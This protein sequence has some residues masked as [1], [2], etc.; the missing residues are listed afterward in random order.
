MTA[1]LEQAYEDCRRVVRASGSSF[2]AGMQLLPLDRRPAIFA[3]YALA[4][5]ID[6]IADGDL[7]TEAKLARFDRLRSELR[8]AEEP[9]NTLVLAVRDAAERFP[10]PL[11]AFQDLLDG[12]ESDV[13][14]RSYATF[15]ELEQYCRCV[16]GSIGRLCLGVFETSD[17]GRAEPLAD[18]LGVALQLGN[19]LRDLAEDRTRGRSYL[20]EADLA[21]FDGDL[22]LAVAFEAE[23]ALG[24]LARGMTLVPLLDRASARCVVA[25]TSAYR[26]LIERIAADP[27]LP[28]RGRV[29]LSPWQ[30]RFIVARSMAGLS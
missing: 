15:E 23:R 18:D 28:L 12:A 6:D 19:I 9:D 17:R 11:E 5:R 2:R 7:S 4:R 27:T 21:R 8:S 26:T 30:K 3:V 14:G 1:T 13:R 25:L 29:V 22:T 20:P 16:A 10:I 24:W